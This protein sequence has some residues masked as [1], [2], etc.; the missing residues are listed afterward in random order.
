M[1]SAVTRVSFLHG[2]L[3]TVVADRAIFNATTKEEKARTAA[4]QF[5]SIV[6]AAVVLAL[7][8]AA[9][10]TRSVVRPLALLTRSTNELSE[11]KLP[12]L[13]EQLQRPDSEDSGFVYEPIEVRSTDEVG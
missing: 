13:L 3:E 11:T 4:L 6:V 2:E 8:L 10:L 7:G 12:K 1:N 9:L 5:V